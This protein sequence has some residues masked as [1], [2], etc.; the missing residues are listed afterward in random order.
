MKTKGGDMGKK[1]V[2]FT[3]FMVYTLLFIVLMVY[4]YRMNKV[5]L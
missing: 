5:G 4:V 3:W 2:F 1:G